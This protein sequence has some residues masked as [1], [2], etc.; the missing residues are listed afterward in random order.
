MPK[1]FQNMGH[2]HRG[3]GAGSN[4]ETK[5]Q[6]RNSSKTRRPASEKAGRPQVGLMGCGFGTVRVKDVPFA[7]RRA[8]R[9]LRRAG[10]EGNG[11]CEWN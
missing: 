3:K 5:Q 9:S 6:R 8:E 4:A 7:C 10:L 1:V 11:L 2:D